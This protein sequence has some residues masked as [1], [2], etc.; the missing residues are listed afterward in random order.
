MLV[1]ENNWCGISDIALSPDLLAILYFLNLLF[2]NFY[3][4]F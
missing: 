4:F 2:F 3:I 1:S